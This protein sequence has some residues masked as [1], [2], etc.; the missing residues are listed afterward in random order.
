V[1]L[2]DVRVQRFVPF[3]CNLPS[4]TNR[5]PYQHGPVTHTLPP[6]YYD[7]YD[8]FIYPRPEFVYS[9]HIY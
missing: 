8:F 6:L 1:L 5:C 3:I 4:R 9:T 7:C 2:S